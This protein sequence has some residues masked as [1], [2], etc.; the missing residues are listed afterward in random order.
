VEPAAQAEAEPYDPPPGPHSAPLPYEESLVEPAARTELD[1]PPAQPETESQ[2]SPPA[3]PQLKLELQR[4]TLPAIQPE[5]GPL[6]PAAL[7]KPGAAGSEAPSDGEPGVGAPGSGAVPAAEPQEPSDQLGSG[8]DDG[9]VASAEPGGAG[10]GEPLGE[11]VSLTGAGEEWETL[12]TARLR[13]GS[14]EE[15]S[16][17]GRF[18]QWA[19]PG[20]GDPNGTAEPAKV[21]YGWQDEPEDDAVTRRDQDAR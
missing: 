11:R 1:E 21:D 13:R 17:A 14:R 6:P 7:G 18:G 2:V 5:S 15:S 4:G 9:G 16:G 19:A 10:T 3:T 12:G 20:E 8:V